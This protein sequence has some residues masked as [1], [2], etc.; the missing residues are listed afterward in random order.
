V[1]YISFRAFATVTVRQCQSVQGIIVL[2][3]V[4]CPCV[5]VHPFISAVVAAVSVMCFGTLPYLTS[6]PGWAGYNACPALRPYQFGPM[7]NP[8]VTKGHSNRL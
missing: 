5:S 8:D 1:I 7:R 3:S 4:R 6:P 2:T